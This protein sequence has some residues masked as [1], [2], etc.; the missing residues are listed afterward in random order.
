MLTMELMVLPVAL[1]V[2]NVNLFH[3][4]IFVGLLLGTIGY[5]GIGTLFAALTASVRPGRPC[6]R[7]SCCR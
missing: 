2:F 6:C 1:V 3:F 5:V 4:W 7:S